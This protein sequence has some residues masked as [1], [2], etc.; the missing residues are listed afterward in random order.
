MPP[1]SAFVALP[2]S[3]VTGLK[4]DGGLAAKAFGQSGQVVV[5][6]AS[7]NFVNWLPLQTNLT[8]S[9]GQFIFADAESSRWPR[10]FYRAR[11]Y[12]GAL[13]PPGIRVGDGSPGFRTIRFGAL[14]RKKF[15]VVCDGSRGFIQALKFFESPFSCNASSVRIHK[16]SIDRHPQ[17]PKKGARR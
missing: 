9:L 13:P 4:P 11:L 6:E 15:F 12:E 14:S 5:I 1:L 16:E 10:R 8:T 7:T 17:S 2:L 3:D